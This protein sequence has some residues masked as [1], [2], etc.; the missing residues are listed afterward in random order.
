MLAIRADFDLSGLQRA[1][2]AV[3][4][5]QMRFATALA[6][7]QLAQ[8]VSA[9][10]TDAVI[11]TF[12]NPTPFTQKG[13]RVAPA[14]KND[15][16]AYVHAKDI[17]AQYLAPYVFGGQRSMGRKKA[18]LV[19]RGVATNQYGN[20][21]RTKLSSLKAKQNVFVGQIKTRKGKLINGVWQ[22]PTAAAR[23]GKVGRAAQSGLK[24]LIQFEDTTEAQ[25][26]FPFYERARAYVAA[27]AGN[28][29]AAA[30]RQA[31]AT[32]RK[33]S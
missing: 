23:K 8:G 20:L 17:A 24:L 11:D 30:L 4:S 3:R 27:N 22:R 1:A 5:D 13:F 2:S 28:E 12:D 33:R 7:T 16:V 15:P 9:E 19:P 31:F 6:L 29:F 26:H 25:K 18:M 10:E 21:A 32:A 14:K